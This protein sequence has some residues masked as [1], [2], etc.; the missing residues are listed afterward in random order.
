MKE[1]LLKASR[2][3]VRAARFALREP[4]S[5]VLVARMAAWVAV[6]SLLMKV[7][8]LERALALVTPLRR[9]AP[10]R[11]PQK[12]QERLSRLVDLLLA[13]DFWFFTPVCWKRAL[14]LY[15][16]LAL[17]G[18]ETRVVFGV[19]K[20]DAS[21]LDGHAWLEASGKPVLEQKAP[22]YNVTFSYPA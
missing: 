19:R 13:T 5:A 3:A 2:K 11:D 7:F 10:A 15:R 21:A 1:R 18:V 17:Q 4:R 14:L 20:G 12:V 22:E 8:P 6:I 16:F 9:T